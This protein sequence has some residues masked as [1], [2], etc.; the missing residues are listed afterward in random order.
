M[1]E[2]SKQLIFKR[3]VVFQQLK[4]SNYWC[5]FEIDH[6][7]SMANLS[8]VYSFTCVINQRGTKSLVFGNLALYRQWG[9]SHT[10]D[11]KELVFK[12]KKCALSESGVSMFLPF[13][14]IVLLLPY[15]VFMFANCDK[16]QDF[17][18]G[19]NVFV[20]VRTG[21]YIIIV[22]FTPLYYA[23]TVNRGR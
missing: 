4:L 21:V 23:L 10:A 11:S 6:I 15:H 18:P 20:T 3:L 17:V 1:A 22:I 5:V 16:S 8:N 7:V 9:F 14:F 13:I 2:E 19:M 12:K